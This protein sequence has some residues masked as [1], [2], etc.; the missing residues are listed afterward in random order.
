MRLSLQHHL[1]DSGSA[2]VLD[3]IQDLTDADLGQLR[4]LDNEQKRSLRVVV[5][6]HTSITG[7]G[8]RHLAVLPNLTGIYLHGTRITDD[9]PFELLS[10][11]VEIVNLDDTRVGDRSI[12]KLSRLPRLRTLRLRHTRVTDHGAFELLRARSLRS[13]CLAETAVGHLAKRRLDNNIL[14]EVLG[15][16]TALRF[17]RHQADRLVR[18]L[19]LQTRPNPLKFR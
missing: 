19:T 2:L 12:E 18:I 3:G 11:K 10:T 4:D 5:L 13:V 14:L 8:L 16:S 17:V 1:Y 9:A 6:S 15:F 7:Q